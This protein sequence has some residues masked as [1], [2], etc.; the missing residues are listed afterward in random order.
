MAMFADLKPAEHCDSWLVTV[1]ERHI[2][3]CTSSDAR[4]YSPKNESG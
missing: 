3:L 1:L 2:R 4:N